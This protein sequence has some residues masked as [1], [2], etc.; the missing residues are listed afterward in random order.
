M[1]SIRE[2]GNAGRERII[3]F[4]ASEAE[5]F[6][7]YSITVTCQLASNQSIPALRNPSVKTSSACIAEPRTH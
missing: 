2:E 4:Y 6:S 7:P 3:A 5:K 1:H